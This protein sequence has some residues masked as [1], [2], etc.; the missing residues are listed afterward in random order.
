MGRY[1]RNCYFVAV[2]FNTVAVL[3]STPK[4]PVTLELPE[5][6][7]SKS[8][9]GLQSAVS[10]FNNKEYK[11][12]KVPVIKLQA[13]GVGYFVAVFFCRGI[14]WNGTVEERY[15]PSLV[16][17]KGGKGFVNKLID[18]LSFELHIS[19]YNYCGPGTKL[20]KRLARNDKGINPLD[21][22]C[23]IHDIAYSKNAEL[24]KRHEAD[25]IL[26]SSALKRV[27][28]RDSGI[29]EKLAA[30]GVTTAMKAKVKLAKI[31][32]QNNN[33]KDIGSAINIAAKAVKGIKKDKRARIIALPK[34]GGFL[35]LIPL[36]AG[37]S[38]LGALAGGASSIASAVNKAKLAQEDLKEKQRH[39]EKI[40]TI[41]MGKG[42]Q[43]KQYKKG[44]GRLPK[45]ALTNIDLNKYAKKF[46]N[47][48]GVFMQDDLPHK[49]KQFEC[50]IINLD[51]S[52]G[53]GTHWTAYIKK[54][55]NV[56]YYVSFGNLMPPTKVA[57][58]FYTST[59][60]PVKITYNHT[61]FQNYNSLN[62]MRTFS[63]SGTESVLSADFYPPIDLRDFDNDFVIGLLSL[64]V[65]NAI[66]NIYKD[67]NMFYIG[68]HKI[69]IPKGTYDI[70]NINSFLNEKI[71]D[72]NRATNDKLF[73]SLTANLNT[74]KCEIKSTQDIDFTAIQLDIYWVFIDGDLLNFRGETITIRAH[75]KAQQQLQQ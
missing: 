48:R 39:N 46:K 31:A 59:Q 37:L 19:S 6:L 74:L 15:F 7:G 35:P 34:T 64:E 56:L 16:E 3:R 20:S 68:S 53:D 17:V 49:I 30:L 66:P 62:S 28:A 11:V 40:E 13:I 72:L 50:G 12:L 23:K 33:P 52:E 55:K 57:S 60:Q 63:F 18:R 10:P 54:N 4:A 21:E 1:R 38:A 32:I 47:F 69:E 75:L 22:A 29:S 71:N 9:Q 14:I 24:D 44:L 2:F 26:A 73:L 41:A 65:Y 43:L 51:S 58:Y 5:G 45:R 8:L 36:F 67:K 61:Q 27:L 25:K 42:L 70:D